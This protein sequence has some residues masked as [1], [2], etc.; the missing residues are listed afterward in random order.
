MADP[1]AG[2]LEYVDRQESF[3][4]AETLKYLYLIFDDVNFMP[5]EKWVF[6]SLVLG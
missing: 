1:S 2:P 3:W 6:K 4:A 5:L